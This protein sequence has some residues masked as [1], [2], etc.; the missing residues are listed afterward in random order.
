MLSAR[1]VLV[2]DDAEVERMLI[3]TY[4]QAQG[5]RIYHAHDGEDGIQKARLLV[6]DCILM[7]AVMP[8]CDGFAAC[9]VLAEDPATSH[10]P[11]IFLSAYS[12]PEQRVRG[13]LAG[14]VDYIGKPYDFDEVRLRL[15]IHLRLKDESIALPT[16]QNGLDTVETSG[17]Y[18]HNLLFQGA[19]VHLLRSLR[20]SPG[21]REL[22]GLI[23]TNAKRLNEA[24]RHCAGVTVSEYLREER[25]KEAAR[26]LRHTDVSII[27]IAERVGFGSGANFSTAFKSRFGITPRQYRHPRADLGSD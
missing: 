26:L 8:R 4:L 16:V 15:A 7:D 22:A 27:E 20:Q 25:M 17:A 1:R 3:S 10:V 6:P 5:C 11:I 2:I 21:V 23:G 13:L 9:R 18:L 19:R 12:E 14:A 24:F